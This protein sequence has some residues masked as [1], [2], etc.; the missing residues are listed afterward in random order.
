MEKTFYT[1][2]VPETEDNECMIQFLNL[3]NLYS[4]Q[5]RRKKCKTTN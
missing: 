5:L 2:L 4:T 1:L 3:T